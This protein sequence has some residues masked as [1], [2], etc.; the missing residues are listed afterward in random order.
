[1]EF[2]QKDF[3]TFVLSHGLIGFFPSPIMLSSGRQSQ[4]YINWRTVA[5]DVYLLDQL[6]E[7]VLSFVQQ[8]KLDIDCFY[9]VPEGATKLGIVCQYKFAHAQ[10][11]YGKQP[12]VMAMGRGKPKDH[13]EEKDRYFVGSPRGKVVV[14]EDVTTTGQ[15]LINTIETLMKQG[16]T[17][18]AALALT[19][20]NENAKSG[21]SVSEELRTR[22]IPYY[23][24]SNATEL[25]P[26]VFRD[27]RIS[28]E[29]EFTKHGEK[30]LR[31]R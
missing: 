27:L 7:Y 9:G 11:A 3:N 31:L 22:K 8:K 19:N 6:V 10:K 30:P 25:L 13:G 23:A 1:M 12:Y 4:W 14:I 5:S 21:L 26:I 29:E 15:S 2:N 28:L 24:L 16:I 20:R 17:V 18:E